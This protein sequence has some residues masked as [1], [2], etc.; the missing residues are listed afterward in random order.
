MRPV[1]GKVRITDES[2]ARFLDRWEW[3]ENEDPT[4]GPCYCWTGATNDDGYGRVKVRLTDG[5]WRHYYTHRL[6][7]AFVVGDIP[8]GKELAHFCSRRTCGCEHHVMPLSHAENMRMIV[9]ASRKP[10][11]TEV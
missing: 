9:P 1:F 7:F 3:V 2:F 4:L 5:T 6:R 11:K 10:K 8:K